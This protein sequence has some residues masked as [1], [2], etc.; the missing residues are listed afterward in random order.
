MPQYFFDVTGGDFS[1]DLVGLD[2]PDMDAARVHAVGLCGA[3][4]NSN[5]AKFWQGEEWLIEA[6]D[7]CGLVL[8]TLV[9]MCR[10]TPIT[11]GTRPLKAVV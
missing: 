9:F 5:A 8:F 3:L 6:K 10:D 4:L 7:D 2:F 1:P 11:R